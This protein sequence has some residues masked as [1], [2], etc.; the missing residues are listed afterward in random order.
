MTA[1]LTLVSHT[2]C[3]YVQRAVIVLSEKGMEFERVDIDLAHET[4]W[5]A[6]GQDAGASRRRAADLRIGGDMRIPR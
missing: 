5:L 2:W 1:T 3:P 6:A 4:D